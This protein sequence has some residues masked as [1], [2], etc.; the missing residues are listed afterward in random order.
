M[1]PLNKQIAVSAGLKWWDSQV[2]FQFSQLLAQSLFGGEDQF[3]V[4]KNPSSHWFANGKLP[5]ND[6]LVCE[7]LM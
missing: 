3:K 7:R 5:N 4:I 6:G 1:C 2:T